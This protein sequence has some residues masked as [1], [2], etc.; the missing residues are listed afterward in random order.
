MAQRSADPVDLF[1][2]RNLRFA[3]KKRRP[4][5]PI[6]R[7]GET[8]PLD[9]YSSSSWGVL[10]PRCSDTGAHPPL[11]QSGDASFALTAKSRSEEAS[12]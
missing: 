3:A 4:D 2:A 12:P 6:E 1:D 8:W 11:T 9:R 10:S 5:Q 7:K